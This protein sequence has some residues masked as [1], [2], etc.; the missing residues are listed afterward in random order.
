MTE[1]EQALEEVSLEKMSKSLSLT[2]APSLMQMFFPASLLSCPAKR[3]SKGTVPSDLSVE[4]PLGLK[5][6]RGLGKL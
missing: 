1:K 6:L 4:L 2:E 5:K 3:G